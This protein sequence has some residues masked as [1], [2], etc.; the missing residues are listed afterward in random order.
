MSY[1]TF[2]EFISFLVIISF[3]SGNYLIEVRVTNCFY[4]TPDN[5]QE[6]EPI[7]TKVA[8]MLQVRQGPMR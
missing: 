7:L 2:N 8:E 1:H 6:P 4:D 5:M 3:V